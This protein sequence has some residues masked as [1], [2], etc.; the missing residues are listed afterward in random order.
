MCYPPFKAYDLKAGREIDILE[1][2]LA[3]MDR[4]FEGYM[5]LDAGKTREVARCPID[6]TERCRG[7]GSP[8]LR[9]DSCMKEGGLK[10]YEKIPRHCKGGRDGAGGRKLPID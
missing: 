10:I 2:P 8:I 1:I 9:H 4:T 3:V 5:R 6:A 7:G